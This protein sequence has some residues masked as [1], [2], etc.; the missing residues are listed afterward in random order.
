[1]SI[2]QLECS[3]YQQPQAVAEPAFARL[4]C[5]PGR[6]GNIGRVLV[7]LGAFLCAWVLPGRI[8]C[9]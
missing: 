2:P 4:G 5:G 6:G 9:G 7:F 8:A 3:F 1:M